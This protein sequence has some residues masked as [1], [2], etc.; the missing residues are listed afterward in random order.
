MHFSCKIPNAILSFL[1]EQGEDI[2]DLY[3]VSPL[4]MELLRDPSCWINAPDLEFFLEDLH[5]FNFKK[6]IDFLV[7]A[8]HQ[9]PHLHSW[10][11]LDSVLKMMPRPQEIFNQPEKFLSHFISPQPPIENI[12]R[13]EE[14]ISFDWPLPAEQYPH[15]TTYLKAALESLPVY[16]GRPMASCHWTGITIQLVW[17]HQMEFVVEDKKDFGHQISPELF[18]GLIQDLQKTQIEREDLQRYIGDLE[19]KIKDME[20]QIPKNE[21][22]SSLAQNTEKNLTQWLSVNDKITPKHDIGS[23]SYIIHQNLARMHD[24]MVRAQ[25]LITML[26]VH[27]GKIQPLA[28]EA[29]KRID[30]D[31]VRAQYPITV[32]ESM[33]LLRKLQKEKLSNE[34]INKGEKHV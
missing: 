18:Q 5:R 25:Q 33:E 6:E 28:K 23:P 1:E 10:G 27:Q 21:G 8:G 11:V 3:D 9:G 4:P 29:M 34:P 17:N 32:S 31:Y 7:Q 24:Y 26:S 30:W 20:S 12:R 2:S 13:T 22:V 15:V 14:S 16:I 19:T